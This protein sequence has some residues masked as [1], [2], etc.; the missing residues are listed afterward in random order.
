MSSF[1]SESHIIAIS[2]TW[3]NSSVCNNEILCQKFSIYRR[4]RDYEKLG[5]LRGGGVLLAVR[6]D[7]RSTQIDLTGLW[8]NISPLIDIVGVKVATDASS[9]C[10]LL[11]YIPPKLSLSEYEAF[12]DNV[13]SLGFVNGKHILIIGDFNIPGYT[14]NLDQLQYDP[15]VSALQGFMNI[16]DINQFNFVRNCNDRI[17]DLVLS[18]KSCAVVRCLETETLLS[19]D[20][21]HPAL[22]ISF[23]LKKPVVT[24]RR[25]SKNFVNEYDFKRADFPNLYASIQNCNWAFLDSINDI[26]TACEKFY[27]ELYRVFDAHVP[28]VKHN[29]NRDYP[30][31][32][33]RAII[34][35]IKK[36]HKFW[37]QYK[38]NGDNDALFH[39]KNLR[40]NIKASIKVAYIN[41]ARRAEK[42]V[43]HNP[44]NFWGFVNAKRGF[45]SLPE[46]MFIDNRT[47]NSP[48]DI[49]NAFAAHFSSSFSV[50]V[51]DIHDLCN[52]PPNQTSVSIV[53]HVSEELVITSLSK[54]KPKLSMGPDKIPAF[55]FEG[56]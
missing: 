52:S 6:D 18:Q 42:Q 24:K 34:S 13:A 7:L 47:F 2:E 56:L 53:E 50:P 3:L 36:K 11:V 5:I 51:I 21:Q 9:I 38:N 39:Y 41:Y 4:D 33:S 28:K 44:K 32:F 23:G 30:P 1:H 40:R 29:P 15:Y 43:K 12:F 19:E 37:R 10:I 46:E 25:F 26:D 35:D 8:D 54:L 27:D 22:N 55:F 48:A 20:A 49:L 16:L 14:S 31:W 17:L 45:D